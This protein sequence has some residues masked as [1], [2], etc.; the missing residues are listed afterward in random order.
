MFLSRTVLRGGA[1]A[2]QFRLPIQRA[3]LNPIAFTIRSL[4]ESVD[5]KFTGSCKWF[6]VKKGFGFITPDD[7]S[8]DVFVHQTN[9]HAKGFRSLEEGETV[10][11]KVFQD[12][13]GRVKAVDVTGPDG[14]FVRG[15]SYTPSH[16]SYDGGY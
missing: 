4:S 1:C 6:D 3:P 14:E 5:D 13:D 15:Q 2:A 16:D 9:I 10:A 8:T 7:G 11:Y 12:M